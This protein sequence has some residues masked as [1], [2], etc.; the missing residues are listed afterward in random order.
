ML[1]G[2]SLS[3]CGSR[4]YQRRVDAAE[5]KVVVHGQA[6][7]EL[8]PVAEHVIEIA[9]AIVHRL[10][11]A[12]GREPAAMHHLDRRPTLERAASAERVAEVALERAHGRFLPEDAE[13]GMRF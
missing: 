13:G 5:R 12:R 8:A 2:D 6:D 10:E 7:V 9:A 11:I 3:V 1:T 4:E